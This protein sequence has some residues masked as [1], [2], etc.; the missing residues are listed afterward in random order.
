VQGRVY[1]RGTGWAFKVDLPRDPAT[2]QRRQRQK[3]GFATR[4]A[5]EEGLTDL[6][7]EIR[8]DVVAG[9]GTIKL[10]DWLTEWLA[11]VK[12]SLRPSTYSLY[13]TAVT[14]WITPRIGALKLAEVTPQVVQRLY[15]DLA[16]S[17]GRS[18]QGLSPR[19][20]RLA[21]QVLQQAFAKAVQWKL[22]ANNP[23]ASGIILPRMEPK[24]MKTLSAEDAKAF[25]DATADDRLGPLWCLLLTT[26]LRRGEALGLRWTDVDLADARLEVRQTVVAVKGTPLISEPKTKTG[27]R[28]VYLSGRTIEALKDQRVRQKADRKL[29]GSAWEDS[30]L[31]FTTTTGGL[32]HPRNVLRDFQIALD[33]AN[34]PKVRLHDLRH[35]V[36]TLL[37]HE[38]AHPKVVQE[39]LGHAN[40]AITLNT[41]SHATPGL[42]REAADMLEGVLKL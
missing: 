19:S 29:V 1:R 36:A 18:G 26:G 5:A 32:L 4:K 41:Y 33:K 7:G 31:V 30:G 22:T 28:T 16:T 27:R 14:S 25:L 2:G 3:G 10:E 11:A 24:E 42:H 20:V 35:T 15:T 12:P 38:G 6:L 37:L 39:L 23:L 21:H 40:V 34:L 8:T 9:T 13:S 17:G